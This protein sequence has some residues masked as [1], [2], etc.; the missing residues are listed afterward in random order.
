MCPEIR[1]NSHD[2]PIL[3]TRCDDDI[4]MHLKRRLS[5]TFIWLKTKMNG[6]LLWTRYWTFRF[7]KK[8][9]NSWHSKRLPVS[10]EWVCSTELVKRVIHFCI[11]MW[12]CLCLFC[13]LIFIKHGTKAMTQGRTLIDYTPT[14]VI[15]SLYLLRYLKLEDATE[16][17]I[18]FSNPSFRPATYIKNIM[19]NIK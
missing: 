19:T 17:E 6:M 8:R 14:T 11:L 1:Q 9:G 13:N 18:L 12:Q 4:K 16:V 15:P 3:P 7:E 10:Q 2:Q 5:L